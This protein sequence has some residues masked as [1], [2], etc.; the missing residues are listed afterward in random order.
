MLDYAETPATRN[1]ATKALCKLLY[2]TM[3]LYLD[4][5]H[6]LTIKHEM[7]EK[8]LRLTGIQAKPL[9][10]VQ[11]TKP[12]KFF[13][14][15]GFEEIEASDIDSYLINHPTHKL[16]IHVNQQEYGIVMDTE[17]IK[18]LA[19]S[20]EDNWTFECK[21]DEDGRLIRPHQFENKEA[22]V[23]IPMYSGKVYFLVS[24]LLSML[25]DSHQI[26]ALVGTP[27]YFTYT[28]SGKNALSCFNPYYMSADH[29]QEGSAKVVYELVKAD[30]SGRGGSKSSKRKPKNR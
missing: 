19:S 2:E 15:I 21:T 16:F 20:V 26:F 10:T 28:A 12:D 30:L 22:Y 14:I 5:P 24:E 18:E 1:S 3:K 23:G 25:E 29:C 17:D 13:D 8:A 9:R 7:F 11:K 27:H 4:D 6:F